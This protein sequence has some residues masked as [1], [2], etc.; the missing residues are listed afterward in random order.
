M[1]LFPNK[2]AEL[3]FKWHKLKIDIQLADN[4]ADFYFYEKDVWWA[5]LGANIGHEEDGKNERFERPV[6][7]LKKFNTHLLLTVPLSSQ[8]KENN[9]YYYKFLLNHQHSSA[10]ISQIR[11]ISS[12]RLIRKIGHLNKGNFDAIRSQI[13]Q[14]I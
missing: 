13:K 2:K 12:K 6:L 14:L 3:I 1:L 8:S 11:I 9:K 10:I 4:K 7:I 5:S